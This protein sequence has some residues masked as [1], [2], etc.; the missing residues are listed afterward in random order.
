MSLL[1]IDIG[2]THIKAGLFELDGTCI[3]IAVRPNV[4]YTDDKGYASYDPEKLWVTAAEAI[5]GVNS[6][7]QRNIAAI[8]IT[9]MAESGLLIDPVTGAYLTDIIPWFDRRTEEV[10]QMIESELNPFEH[11]IKTGI[12]PSYKYGLAKLLWLKQQ[13]ASLQKEAVWL[14]TSDFIAYKLTGRLGTDYSLAA[15]TY[16]FRI[17]KKEWDAPTIRHFGLNP[18]LFP[19]ARPSGSVVGNISTESFER[20]GLHKGIPV[21]VSG[22]DHVCAAMAVGAVKP[23]FVSDSIGT[24]ETLV[25]TLNE[26]A[27]G[28]KE[29]ESGFNYGCHVVPERFFWMGA[30]QSSGGSIEWIRNILS[31]G[32][33]SYEE[34]HRLLDPAPTGPTGILY[35]PYLAGSGSPQ[36]DPQAKG[37]FI[38]L[39][40][41][42]RKEHLLKALLEGTSYEL[43]YMRRAA[44]EVEQ[45]KI[46]NI[47]AVGGG[48]KNSHWMQ[49]KSDVTNCTL[50]IPGISEAGLLGAAMIA[51]WGA[52]IY[53]NEE[54]V[55]G[56]LSQSATKEVVPNPENHQKYRQIFEGGYLYLQEPLRNFYQKS[57]H[58]N[59]TF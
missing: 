59:I 20:L 41:S 13:N 39:K 16:V 56:C 55:M 5:R 26:R 53:S 19:E 17:D 31:S 8:G 57:Y 42:H 9:S 45:I 46:T 58:K 30:I 33:L 11:F 12:R 1:G 43:E 22:H 18:S 50:R 3:H 51:G 38:G 23:G 27:L 40:S 7:A 10:S 52:G 47:A 25:G 6:D 48:T 28:R 15:R 4:S 44:E 54:E 34:I 37:A 32:S 14:S 2:T 49:I 36:P 35:F 21:A 24:A 29:Y